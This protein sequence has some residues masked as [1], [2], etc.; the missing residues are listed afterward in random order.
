MNKVDQVLDEAASSLELLISSIDTTKSGG[1]KWCR[2]D[3]WNESWTQ[4]DK[5]KVI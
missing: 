2:N 1:V 4:V 3:A 5:V